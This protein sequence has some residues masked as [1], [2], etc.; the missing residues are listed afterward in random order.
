MDKSECGIIIDMLPNYL[1]HNG[2]LSGDETSRVLTHL[3]VCEG[4]RNEAAFLLTLKK[5]SA[6]LA[7][8]VPENIINS[9]FNKIDEVA[10]ECEHEDVLTV[11]VAFGLIRDALYT[12]RKVVNFAYQN[13]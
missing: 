10:N 4:C 8:D 6:A 13:I 7:A 12:A 3:A 9:V 1:N 2:N 11:S 5:I